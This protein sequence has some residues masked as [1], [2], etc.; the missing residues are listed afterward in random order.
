MKIL[1]KVPLRLVKQDG[2]TWS[3]LTEG[4]AQNSD[5]MSAFQCFSGMQRAG[6][7][8]DATTFLCLLSACSHLGLVNEGCLH[9]QSM[10]EHYGIAPTLEHYNSMVD[11]FGHAGYLNEAEDLLETIPFQHNLVGWTSL[12]SSC[13]THA[14]MDLGKRCFDHLIT[15]NCENATGFVLMLNIYGH[16]GMWENVEEM[17]ELRIHANAWKQ[18]AKA[19]IEIDFQVHEFIVGDRIHSKSDDI[20]AKLRRLEMQLREEG[21]KPRCDLVTLTQFTNVI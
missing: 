16:A 21:Y 10:R 9:F 8:P 13:R 12:L 19:S 3:T 17:E 14:N 20:N 2:V 6:F 4:Y 15:L 18:P 7:K 1:S 11:L 5:Y